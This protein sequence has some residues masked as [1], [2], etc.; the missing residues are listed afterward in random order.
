MKRRITYRCRVGFH[1]GAAPSPTTGT[2]CDDRE[3]GFTL[4]E[5][6][7]AFAILSIVLLTLFS[8][9]ST[10]LL[11]DRRAE[12]TRIALRLAKA[13]LETV[14]VATPLTPG[15]TTGRFENGMEWRL[16]VQPYTF[17]SP[18]VTPAYWVKI[19]VRPP[20]G[21]SQPTFAAARAGPMASTPSVTLT[22]LKLVTS[23][24]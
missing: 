12:F 18:K 23:L 19:I 2:I 17:A 1:R 4:V 7:V 14:G 9:L 5:V 20:S 16:S 3:T 24:Q 11:G 22:T 21:S 10:A 13:E 8:G 6:L 15:E